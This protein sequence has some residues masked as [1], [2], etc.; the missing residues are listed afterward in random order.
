M[1]KRWRFNVK[2]HMHLLYIFLITD[3]FFFFFYV[4]VKHDKGEIC[5]TSFMVISFFWL[6]CIDQVDL[7]FIYREALYLKCFYSNYILGKKGQN[8]WP[9]LLFFSQKKKENYIFISTWIHFCFW[10]YPLSKLALMEM[11]SLKLEL[12]S[13]YWF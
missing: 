11:C 10:R 5:L 8:M 6:N 7:Y 4:E 12:Q 2:D 13:I 1:G 9:N 3:A